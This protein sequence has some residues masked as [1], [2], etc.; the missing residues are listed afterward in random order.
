MAD[1]AVKTFPYFLNSIRYMLNLG[2]L[3]HVEKVQL[4]RQKETR[5]VA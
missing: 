4:L 1:F 5:A 3:N 2:L